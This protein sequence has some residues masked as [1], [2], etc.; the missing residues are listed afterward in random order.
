MGILITTQE[1]YGSLTQLMHKLDMV[2]NH[3]FTPLQLL[4]EKST[5]FQV[6][7]VGYIQKR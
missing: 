6:D 1:A 7:V 3:N 2:L 5:N 4:M